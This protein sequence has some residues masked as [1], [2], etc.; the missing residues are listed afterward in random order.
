MADKDSAT[1]ASCARVFILHLTFASFLSLSLPLYVTSS[2]V[3]MRLQ[4]VTAVAAWAVV[5]VC[6]SLPGTR[7]IWSR[8]TDYKELSEKLSTSAKAYYPSSDEFKQANT[9]WSNLKVPT[10]NIV[11][12]PGTE[13]DVV[14]TVRFYASFIYLYISLQFH[15]FTPRRM[16]NASWSYQLI[17]ARNNSPLI[18]L[19]R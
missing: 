19:Y 5:S 8:D 13:N 17:R 3:K 6:Q 14:E 4:A 18:S 15:Y 7:T 1:A 9:R 11:I 2:Q 12:V 10:V 16:A